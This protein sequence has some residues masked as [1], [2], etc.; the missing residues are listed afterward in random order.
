MMKHSSSGAAALLL[1][2]GGATRGQAAPW[3]DPA[4]PSFLIPAAEIV[5]FEHLLNPYDRNY[6]EEGGCRS[7]LSSI[8]RNLHFGWIIDDDPFSFGDAAMLDMLGREHCIG[9]L[10]SHDDGTRENIL[11]GQVRLAVR[12]NGHHALEL[13]LVSS[14]HSSNVFDV[15]GGL[16]EVGA[17][18]LFYTYVSDTGF[19]AVK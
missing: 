4:S 3:G 8:K 10:G 16:E 17:R 19:G 1:A 7:N 5:G 18:S 11:R 2:A 9:G 6:E 12:V 15:P 13:H 14:V